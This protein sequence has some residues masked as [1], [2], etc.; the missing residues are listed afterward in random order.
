MYRR[1][2]SNGYRA[3]ALLQWKS[4]FWKMPCDF[5]VKRRRRQRGKCSALAAVVLHSLSLSF[6]SRA[7][8]VSHVNTKCVAGNWTVHYQLLNKIQ[9]KR[10]KFTRKYSKT[11]RQ[12]RDDRRNITNTS[13]ASNRDT[14]HWLKGVEKVACAQNSFSFSDWYFK[15][16]HVFIHFGKINI[17]ILFILLCGRCCPAPS[18]YT[19]S[20]DHR[21]QNQKRKN[22]DFSGESNSK[23]DGIIFVH[24]FG[25]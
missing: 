23:L 2:D 24:F 15:S 18:L 12:R 9:L 1:F 20:F 3:A 17:F 5:F 7:R 13:T 4:L 25:K 19:N 11:R 14:A 10:G 16:S 6:E 8:C 21:T 22:N